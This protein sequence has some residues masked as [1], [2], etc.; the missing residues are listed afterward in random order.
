M[1][2]TVELGRTTR[3]RQVGLAAAAL[4]APW[5]IVVA[6]TGDSISK[7]HG[8]DDLTPRGDLALSAA[9]ATLD[10]WSS[11]AA[12]LGAILFVP[13]VI[14]AM[15]LVR[16]RAARLG[17]IGGVLMA[18]AYIC[19]FAMIF[20]GFTTLAMGRTDGSVSTDAAILQ[21]FLDEPLTLWVF[22]LF[23]VGNLLGTLLLG[24]ALFRSGAIPKWAALSILGW[25][26]L[27]ALGLPWFEVVGAVLQ[28]IG[29]AYV[30]WAIL[31]RPS[32][33]TVAPKPYELLRK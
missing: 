3:V 10:R 18:A 5:C 2:A 15:K 33:T 12:L 27:H 11:F 8:G 31:A 4:V 24:L 1:N 29:M 20:H 19:Y 17:L 22:L 26:V 25:P 9:H 6:N 14:G 28:A 13:A 16:T 21:A 23:V 7:I 30:A 32:Q